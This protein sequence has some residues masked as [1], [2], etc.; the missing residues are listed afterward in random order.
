MYLLYIIISCGWTTPFII[1]C[2]SPSLHR[3]PLQS[4]VH[5][6]SPEAAVYMLALFIPL[7]YRAWAL[8]SNVCLLH[9]SWSRF[10][11]CSTAS[12]FD[13]IASPFTESV[14]RCFVICVCCLLAAFCGIH[15]LLFLCFSFTNFY[16][17]EWVRSQR[18]FHFTSGF[19][20]S[21]RYL[22]STPHVLL[23]QTSPQI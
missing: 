9:A 10:L 19:L 5:P 16:I 17:T 15:S 11:S 22:V 7:L 8:K 21:S 12:A 6:R 2:P 13:W 4:S 14:N 18:P 3:P 1:E 20:L 23:C